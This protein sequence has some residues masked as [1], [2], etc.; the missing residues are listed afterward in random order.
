[1]CKSPSVS[2]SIGTRSPSSLRYCLCHRLGL[3]VLSQTHTLPSSLQLMGDPRLGAWQPHLGRPAAGT[4]LQSRTPYATQCPRSVVDSRLEAEARSLAGGQVSDPVRRTTLS[5][6]A[7][8]ALQQLA[9]VFSFL[10]LVA[11]I[12]SRGL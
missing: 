11:T 8:A 5:A 12:V 2:S 10:G 9:R 3:V 1:M 6:A 7:M 4:L